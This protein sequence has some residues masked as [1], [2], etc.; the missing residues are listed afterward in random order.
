M[1]EL[2]CIFCKNCSDKDNLIEIDQN[3]VDFDAKIVAFSTMIE[4]LFTKK[5]FIKILRF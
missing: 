4:D 3:A 1:S 2:S 5:V